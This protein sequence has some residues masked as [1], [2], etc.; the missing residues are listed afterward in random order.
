LASDEARDARAGVMLGVAAYTLW[1]LIPL[2]FRLLRSIPSLEVL[3]HRAWWAFVTLAVI[4]VAMRRASAV[5]AALSKPRTALTLAGST[6]LIAINWFVYI[7][8]VSTEQIVQASLGYFITPLANMAI[9]LVVLGERLRW[10]QTAALLPAVI[11]VVVL[12]VQAGQ[13]PWIA[14]ILAISFSLYGLLR[15]I[16]AA[17]ALVGLFTETMFLTPLALG[18]LA[19][20]GL[21]ERNTFSFAAP[22]LSLLLALAGPVTTGPLLCFAAAARRLRMTTLGFLQ[23]L[24]PT[25]Q[26]LVAV[27][28]F[29]EPFTAAQRTA[30]PLIWLAVG[31]YLVDAVQAARSRAGRSKS[32]AT[33]RTRGHASG[34][35]LARRVPRREIRENEQSHDR[36][37]ADDAGRRRSEDYDGVE[38]HEYQKAVDGD[39]N[40][41]SSTR[42][43]ARRG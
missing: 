42:V 4:I 30:F 6:V 15:K 18:Y 40:R 8:A 3:A 21:D 37:D 27:F 22:D 13:L 28:L 29:D 39:I 31:L 17:D 24:A 7:Y 14:L 16:A 19:V 41:P 35:R 25:L 20:L 34:R 2:Y 9:G 11:G 38:R 1:G 36:R 26:F 12:A 23:F 32:N 33:K 5:V 43:A 10:L